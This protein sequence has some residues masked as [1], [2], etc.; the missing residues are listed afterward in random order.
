MLRLWLKLGE[1]VKLGFHHIDERPCRMT[2]LDQYLAGPW[3]GCAVTHL[4]YNGQFI[5]RAGL[6]V[7]YGE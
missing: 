1:H 7:Q 6:Y 3:S 4:V 5:V 2:G